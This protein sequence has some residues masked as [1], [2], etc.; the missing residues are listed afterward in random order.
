[1]Q[2]VLKITVAA[3][4]LALAGC[5]T[6]EGWMAGSI[7]D[8]IPKLRD[9]LPRTTKVYFADPVKSGGYKLHARNKIQVQNAFGKAL[10]GI[11]VDHST[12]T[13][14]CD[15]AFHVVVDNWHYADAGF[16]GVGDR[17]EIALSVIVMNRKTDRV[18]T[19]ST[20]V[21]R[22]LDPLVKRYVESLFKKKDD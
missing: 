9:K 3:F 15:V 20:L 19:R 1:M 6:V 22:S 12:K 4:A 7:E 16:A 14:G 2:R 8:G 13:N 11:G 21:A 10:D 17:D 5:S 18:L